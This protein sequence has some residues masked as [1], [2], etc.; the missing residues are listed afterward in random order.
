MNSITNLLEDLYDHSENYE[1]LA[2]HIHIIFQEIAD[3][4]KYPPTAQDAIKALNLVF[5]Y[6]ISRSDHERWH[7][8]LVDAL[9]HAKMLHDNNM[10]IKIW[11]QIGEH[12]LKGS[13]YE[14]AYQAFL[15]AYEHATKNNSSTE[16]KL[17]AK[18]GLLRA[19]TM[20]NKQDLRE[21][22]VEEIRQLMGYIYYTPILIGLAH[23][24]LATH[25]L[26]SLEIPKALGHAQYALALLYREGQDIDITVA[27]LTL[28]EI[29]RV[30]G[31]LNLAKRSLSLGHIHLKN[32]FHDQQ[33]AFYAYERGTVAHMEQEYE[34][35]TYWLGM[36]L[37]KFARL[38]CYRSH[39][40]AAHHMLG[41]AQV[42]LSE[43]E[44]AG[45][46]LEEALHIWR[47]LD[48][49][50]EY[51]NVLFAK[52]FLAQR[53]GD[54]EKA[55]TLYDKALEECELSEDS[56][57]LQAL[58][59]KILKDKQEMVGDYSRVLKR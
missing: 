41:L 19:Q 57:R 50:Y 26:H 17:L 49:Q 32:Q 4:I 59:T 10:L 58:R 29:Y 1:W 5:P 12:Y 43:F 22:A 28:A 21:Q 56:S 45:V 9:Q 2:Q 27:A 44:Q 15:N 6:A 30:C 25:H 18:V 7:R 48:N 40:G 54:K 13:N 55:S 39:Q 46:N 35:A 36:A 3:K 8:L 11:E 53:E 51:I 47:E 38:K 16:G 33:M 24:A 52:G 20:R 14:S 31:R 42:Y 23:H 37:D 34:T